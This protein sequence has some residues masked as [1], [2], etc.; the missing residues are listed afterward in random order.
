MW[1]GHGA[2]ATEYVPRSFVVSMTLFS[3]EISKSVKSVLMLYINCNI[4]V[5]HHTE[6]QVLVYTR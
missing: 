5:V 2:V 4:R 1:H 3:F 6:C